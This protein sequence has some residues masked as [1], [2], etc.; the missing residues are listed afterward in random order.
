[1]RAVA[2][3]RSARPSRLPRS[4]QEPQDLIVQS[5]TSVRD[6]GLLE[7]VIMPEFQ[8]QYPQWRLK[9]VAVGT[10]QA[11]TNARAGQGDVLDHPR[12]RARGAVR[13]RRLLPR[14]RGPDDHVERLRRSSARPAIRPASAQPAPRRRRRVRG[15]RRRRRGRAGRR[16]S[17]AGTTPGRTPRRRTSGSSR[18]WRATRPT[19]PPGSGAANP[20]WY[21]KAGL[22]M[23]DTLR[24]T[25]QCPAGGC[26]TI[27]DRGTLQQLIANG[28]I[29]ALPDRDGG[30]RTQRRAAAIGADGQ[31]VPRLRAD[32]G[33]GPVRQD[34]GRAGLPR[35]PHHA[36]LPGAPAQLPHAPRSPASSPRRSR[37]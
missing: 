27:T 6:S 21:T 2:G 16:S 23:A 29:T 5:T 11:I 33:Q 20:S 36:R 25:Q 24:L 22:G 34:G 37:R 9:F 8:R 30:S 17:R 18:R 31:P 4:A 3:R 15:D 19:S 1:M 14:A 13:R 7:Q 32:P 35:L 28:A 10:G 12:A 26:Y